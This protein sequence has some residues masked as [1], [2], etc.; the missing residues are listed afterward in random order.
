MVP[1]IVLGVFI[2]CKIIFVHSTVTYNVTVDR[3][4]PSTVIPDIYYG[5][6]FDFW[7]YNDPR[8]G[9]KWGNAS[10]LTVN[11]SNENL[12]TLASA[13]SPAYLRI[14]GSS[15]DS[16]IYNITGQCNQP[17]PPAM[18][19]Y[20]CS[21]IAPANYSCMTM[22]RWN[23]ITTF[24]HKIDAKLLFGLNCCYG[25]WNRSTSVNLTMI[26]QFLNFTLNSAQIENIANLY[27]FELCNELQGTVDSNIYATDFVRVKNSINTLWDIKQNETKYPITHPVMVGPDTTLDFH[28]ME[29]ILSNVS[30]ITE[31][32]VENT[33]HALTYHQYPDC[34]FP[35]SN[36]S[37]FDLNCLNGISSVA[38][39]A[40]SIG[41][42]YNVPGWV[43][44]SAEHAGG[45]IYNVTNVFA[46]SFY[47]MYQL[48]DV[49][50]NGVTAV[51]RQC[52][53][54]GDYE[55]INK[56]TFLPN[57]DYFMLYIWKQLF[58][59]NVFNVNLTDSSSGKIPNYETYI[60][61]W[62]FDSS[63]YISGSENGINHVLIVLI[64]Y[65]LTNAAVVNLNVIGATSNDDEYIWQEFHIQGNGHG[66]D[67]LQSNDISINDN[68]LKFDAQTQTLPDFSQWGI[69]S[70]GIVELEPASI[71]L[72]NGWQPQ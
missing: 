72:V 62:A 29:H 39:D 63:N 35:N 56:T 61:N 44:E 7:K 64:N 34:G 14:G 26:N 20:Q 19:G 60:R 23:E 45:G 38:K 68:N 66:I 11:L 28:Y 33:I 71:V 52:L 13:I 47:Y 1:Y 6:T 65:H 51:M 49:I 54:G 3:S 57:S 46:S 22:E 18:E 48:C 4:T 59:K 5:F 25:R 69:E 9:E 31:D 32:N 43:G 12:L 2:L 36:I 21:K 10:I 15:E 27:G 24:A 17:V 40:V 37:V 30:F 58:G 53:V 8:Y 67:G 55:L 42:K 41:S 70:V 50:E 16:I